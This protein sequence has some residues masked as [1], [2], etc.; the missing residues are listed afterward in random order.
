MQTFK[1]ILRFR[2]DDEI[3]NALRNVRKLSEYVRQAVREMGMLILNLNTK[4][5]L[6]KLKVNVLCVKARDKLNK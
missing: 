1:K 6:M 3:V 2:F 4:T 5:G